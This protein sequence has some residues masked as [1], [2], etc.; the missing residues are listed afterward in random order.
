MKLGMR[1]S[2]FDPALF[3][4]WGGAILKEGSLHSCK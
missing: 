3:V 2:R 1:M 4:F